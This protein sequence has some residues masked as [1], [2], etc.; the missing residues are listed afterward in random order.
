M[1]EFVVG[2]IIMGIVVAYALWRSKKPSKQTEFDR[3]NEQRYW[4]EKEGEKPVI[5]PAGASKDR[6][7]DDGTNDSDDDD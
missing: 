5:V 7:G 2:I 3:L 6:S 4:A 1:G